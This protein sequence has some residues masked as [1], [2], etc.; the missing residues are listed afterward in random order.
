MVTYKVEINKLLFRLAQSLGSVRRLYCGGPILHT[1]PI[2]QP[3]SLVE[4]N[5]I[6]MSSGLNA[7][8]WK[9]KLMIHTANEILQ[10]YAI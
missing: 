5:T 2:Q 8:S 9:I 7:S 3:E 10:P 6:N 4:T 1:K